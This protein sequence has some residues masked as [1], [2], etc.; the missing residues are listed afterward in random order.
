MRP[1]GGGFLNQLW[2]QGALFATTAAKT[3]I[4]TYDETDN[5]PELVRQGY[6]RLDIGIA[7]TFPREFVTHTF[8]FETTPGS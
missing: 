1:A 5:P 3:Y 8:Q 2:Q 4:V 7:A 6:L